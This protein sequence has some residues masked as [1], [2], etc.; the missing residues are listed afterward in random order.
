M[1]DPNHWAFPPSLQPKAAEVR[2][3]LAAT[4]NAVVALHA[5]VPEDAFTASIL[6]TDRTGNGVVIADD[7]LVL[8]IGYLITEAETIWLTAHDGR[9]VPATPLA[10]DFATG[11][12]LVQPLARLEV[13]PLAMAKPGALAAID[14]GAEVYA[15]S[16]GG[17]AHALA[18]RVFAKR[19]FAGYWEY[20]LDE[21]LFIRP[22]HPE[23]SGAALVDAHGMLVGLGSLFVQ[24]RDGDDEIKGNMFVPIE[25]LA[26][27]LDDLRSHG[28]SRHPARPWLGI[29]TAEDE[30]RLI[31]QGVA[32]GGPADRAGVR[33]G[34][35]VV[36]AAGVRVT[37]LPEFYRAV[38]RSG[39]AG[40]AVPLVLSRGGA[41]RTV[42]LRSADRGSFLKKPRLQ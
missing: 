5:E 20:L 37:T 32:T 8:T 30:G 34:D 33:P 7:G 1:A 24:E 38:W 10:Y 17:R 42:E 19:E 6:G 2:F 25:L 11:F 21:A 31:V 40:V 22:P 23:W 12:G 27:M 3:D 9:V 13:P 28:G 16:H 35:G 18:A 36:E 41:S 39:P 4:M 14:V 15:L 26:P 29:Y